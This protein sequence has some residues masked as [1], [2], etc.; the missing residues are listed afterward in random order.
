MKVK[1][2]DLNAQWQVIK[3]EST[4]GIDRLF[5]R[6]NFILGEEVSQFEDSFA[7]Y[8]GCKY[9]VG[10]SNGTDALKL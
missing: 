3:E 1:F 7:K 6:S 2:N 9:A 10:V 5:E 8:V 4:K